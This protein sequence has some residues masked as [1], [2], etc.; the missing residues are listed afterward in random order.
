MRCSNKTCALDAMDGA[1]YCE[2]H[3][4][5]KGAPRPGVDTARSAAG[6]QIQEGAEKGG[7]SSGAGARRP[8]FRRPTENPT[9]LG[10]ATSIKVE[11]VAA[12]RISGKGEAH[13]SAKPTRS[14]TKDR[15]KG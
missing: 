8:A 1:N 10:K 6:G 3:L 13:S 7:T 4:K 9:L 14:P 11:S 5:L 15:S 2:L 12:K